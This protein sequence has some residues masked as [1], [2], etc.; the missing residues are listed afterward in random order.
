MLLVAVVMVH[1]ENVLLLRGRNRDAKKKEGH[2]GAGVAFKAPEA[3]LE[4]ATL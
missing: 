1:R 2:T 4:P 3:G